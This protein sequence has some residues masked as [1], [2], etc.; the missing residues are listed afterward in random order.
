MAKKEPGYLF[1]SMD[2]E[3]LNKYSNYN[4]TQ[5]LR[6]PAGAATF[7]QWKRRYFRQNFLRHLTRDS[8]GR[9]LDVGCGFGVYVD[10]MRKSGYRNVEGVDVS[11]DQIEYARTHFG[12]ECVTCA[13]ARHYLKKKENTYDVIMAIDVLEHLTFDELI[14]LTRELHRSLK[15]GGR[16]VAQAPNGYALM[17][18]IVYSDLTHTRA[19]TPESFEQLFL[20]SGF[21]K[22]PSFF[23]AFPPQDDAIG[24][25]KKLLWKLAFRPL[26]SLYSLVAAGNATR[27]IFSHNMIAVV[28]K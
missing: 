25:T 19:F 1:S 3:N 20:L 6:V 8:A 28:E 17:N 23:E 13:D 7:I 14:D 21:T 10:E 5:A 22:P 24:M 11:E 18:H 16:L 26:L 27:R 15:P 2:G 4:K 9:I 12:L